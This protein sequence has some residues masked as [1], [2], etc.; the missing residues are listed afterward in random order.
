MSRFWDQRR[1]EMNL[2]FVDFADAGEGELQRLRASLHFLMTEVES[3]DVCAILRRFL[4]IMG[5]AQM[6]ADW[7][8]E[9]HDIVAISRECSADYEEERQAWLAWMKQADE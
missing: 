1:F 9:A 8:D 4:S 5:S 2:A 7:V 6:W 3:E